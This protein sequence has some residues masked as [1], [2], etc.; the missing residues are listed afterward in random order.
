MRRL[1]VA[2]ALVTE[3]VLQANRDVRANPFVFLRVGALIFL[4]GMRCNCKRSHFLKGFVARRKSRLVQQ[5][6][7]KIVASHSVGTEIFSIDVTAVGKNICRR[8]CVWTR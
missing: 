7:P 6:R 4:S 5:G 2:Q 1:F 3:I 8:A